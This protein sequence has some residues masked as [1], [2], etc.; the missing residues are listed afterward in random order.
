MENSLKFDRMILP[1]IYIKLIETRCKYVNM[2]TIESRILFQ[3]MQNFG[4]PFI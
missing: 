4:T 2:L 1:Q 3:I